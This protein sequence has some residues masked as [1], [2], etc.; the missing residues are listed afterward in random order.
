MDFGLPPREL[1][2]VL[3]STPDSLPELESPPNFHEL[4]EV[5]VVTE[6]KGDQ[7]RRT[8]SPRSLRKYITSCSRPK[9][10]SSFYVD[11]RDKTVFR[12]WTEEEVI[13]SLN[14]GTEDE[15][16]RGHQLHSVLLPLQTKTTPTSESPPTVIT[17]S[18]AP[19]PSPEVPARADRCPQYQQEVC[20]VVPPGSRV[21]S[22][23][24]ASSRPSSPDKPPTPGRPAPLVPG[25]PPTQPI[26][27]PSPS[28]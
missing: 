16:D 19:R 2:E 8:I 4:L 28:V 7:E 14:L 27:V 9:S 6:W 22:S 20:P 23:A 24:G 5:E 15:A 18:P 25:A 13:N 1:V 26:A 21:S 10:T 11:P 12:E 17:S 3:S